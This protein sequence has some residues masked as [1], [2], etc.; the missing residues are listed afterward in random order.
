[1]EHGVEMS[2]SISLPPTHHV[3]A[4]ARARMPSS[5][6]L[7]RK[8]LYVPVTALDIMVITSGANAAN[9]EGP[10]GLDGRELPGGRHDAGIM[11]SRWEETISRKKDTE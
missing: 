8:R 6:D 10:D 7:L 3:S 5:L 11:R 1:M 4:R 9:H 2:V